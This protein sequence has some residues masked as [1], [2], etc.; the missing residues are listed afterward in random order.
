MNF[1]ID[2][3]GVPDW[4]VMVALCLAAF[5]TFKLLSLRG[6]RANGV[7]SGVAMKAAFVVMWVGMDATV[8]LDHRRTVVRRPDAADWALALGCGAIGAALLWGAAAWLMPRSAYV[9]GAVGLAG[10]VVLVHFAAFRMLAFAWQLAGRDAR[11]IMQCPVA[12]TSL[13]EFWGKRWNMGFRDVAQQWVFRP[14][15]RRW[16]VTAATLAV[17]AASGLL[18]EIVISV[19]A[20]GGF[21]LPT[22]YFMLQGLGLLIERS[23]TGRRLRLASGIRGWL[24]TVFFTVAPAAILFPPIFIERVMLPLLHVIGVTHGGLP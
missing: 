1:A 18:H 24:F 8:F 6:A 19:P 10:M 22:V 17:F 20:R 4:S 13:A 9:A 2:P 14:A 5:F 15:A 23:A 16:G 3:W 12:A 21:G 11:P 7:T